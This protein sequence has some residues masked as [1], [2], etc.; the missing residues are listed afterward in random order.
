MFFVSACT[1]L[2]SRTHSLRRKNDSV[3]SRSAPATG[4]SK[5][6]MGI[7]LI[8]GSLFASQAQV[9]TGDRQPSNYI[10]LSPSAA[11]ASG[12]AVSPAKEPPAAT[13]LRTP[14][15]F[16]PNQG[17]ADPKVRFLSRGSGYSLAL[18][19]SAAV[20]TLHRKGKGLDRHG[21]SRIFARGRRS[22]AYKPVETDVVS[23][24]LA[25]A[26]PVHSISGSNPLGGITNYFIGKDPSKWQTKVPTYASVR[27]GAVYPGVDLVYYGNQRRLEYDFIVAPH[28]DP[29]QIKLHFSGAQGLRLDGDGNLKVIA[30]DGEVVFQKP[31]VYQE[32]KGSRI[33]VDGRFTLLAD[34]TVGFKV[35]GYDRGRPLVIDP[36]L[37]YST[38]LGGS[39][40][41][42]GTAI[43]VDAAGNIY[44]IGF[45]ADADFPVTA[46]AFQTT[47]TVD[48]TVAYVAKLNPAGSALVYATYLGGTSSTTHAE[49]SDAYGMAVDTAG[50]VYICGETYTNDFPVTTGAFQTKNNG[51][52][53]D[54]QNA[55]ISKLS[56][57]GTALVYSTYLGGTG[58]DI[59]GDVLDGDS[60]LRMT[61]DAAGSAYVI[62]TAHS[63]DFPTTSGAYQA[64][65][66]AAANLAS[67][68][69]VAKLNPTGTAL[70]Y[71][72]YLG[73]SGIPASSSSL[74]EEGGGESGYG[75]AVVATGEPLAKLM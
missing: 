75:I 62:G 17:Q 36:T 7:P 68:A 56:P 53:N 59:D 11:G 25:G 60:P 64:T 55:F 18:T 13:Y 51:Y 1:V 26:S 42:A 10:A 4:R 3:E 34:H 38:Y 74:D 35:G 24:E 31:A 45:S 65:N 70:V 50:S 23:M 67:N 69:F 73:G 61:V 63:T 14:L 57:D 72:T 15:S 40:E 49:G 8:L 39:T 32:R 58:L 5:L 71:S 21:L 12:K 41:D 66:K 29:K 37:S 54:V 33:P 6:L 16:E 20:L 44:V 27:Y 43:S 52:A 46:G 28:A 47:N 19:D 48:N 9:Q 2:M 22:P 30:D